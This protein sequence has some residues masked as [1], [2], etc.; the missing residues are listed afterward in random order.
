MADKHYQAAMIGGHG[1][2]ADVCLRCGVLIATSPEV[3]EP[4]KL[5]VREGHDLF[6]EALDRLEHRVAAIEKLL[7]TYAEHSRG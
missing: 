5:T 4:G 3:V 2:A 1:V 6:H 7:L